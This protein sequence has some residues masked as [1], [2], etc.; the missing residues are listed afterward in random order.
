MYGQW[1]HRMRVQFFHEKYG[2]EAISK[3]YV[4]RLVDDAVVATFDPGAHRMLTGVDRDGVDYVVVCE[5]RGSGS[6]VKPGCVDRWPDGQDRQAVQALHA[7]AH[8]D[9]RSGDRNPDELLH[10]AR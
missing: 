7:L 10:G 4:L 1:A 2:T 8:S 3:S 9:P 5:Y 6:D